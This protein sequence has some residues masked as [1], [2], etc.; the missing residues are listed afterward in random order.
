MSLTHTNSVVNFE[1]ELL[2]TK[3]I[4]LGVADN[5][6]K[7]VGTIDAIMRITIGLTGIAWGT[8]RMVHDPHRSLPMLVTLAS[9]MKVAEGVTRFCPMLAAFNT[10]SKEMVDNMAGNMTDMT[11]NM[12][13]M[14][15]K[16]MENPVIKQFT[17]QEKNYESTKEKDQ[18]N[19]N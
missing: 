19:L 7:N 12:K 3:N 13:D 4:L 14:T 5:M 17:S 15:N 1:T 8:A 18:T 6:K 16:A 2:M 9:A 11:Q 10:S